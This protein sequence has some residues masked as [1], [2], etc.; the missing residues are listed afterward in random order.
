MGM[1]CEERDVEWEGEIEECLMN[2]INSQYTVVNY[3][4]SH[5][6]S[7]SNSEWHIKQGVSGEGREREREILILKS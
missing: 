5:D 4:L 6:I 3:V 2:E 1:G 7:K